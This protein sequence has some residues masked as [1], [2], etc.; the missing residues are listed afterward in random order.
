[1]L[2]IEITIFDLT[3][4]H[5]GI[6]L[7]AGDIKIMLIIE[8]AK[9]EITGGHIGI[10]L[11]IEMTKSELTGGHIGIMLIIEIAKIE[12][13]GGHIGFML[14]I[15]ITKLELTGGHIGIML[16]I[17]ITKL[18]LTAGHIG[19]MLMIEIPFSPFLF[20]VKVFSNF[21]ISY[22]MRL[23]LDE[24]AFSYFF[25]ILFRLV[26]LFSL[27]EVSHIVILPFKITEEKDA[28]DLKL[29]K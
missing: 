13:T 4:G 26:T 14:T 25:F 27:T 1:M 22:N 20:M 3:G 5:I 8:I 21:E 12:I 7:T 15:E 17:E 9:I 11:I 29:K 23:K 2:S 24:I 16:I 6:M 19:I 28:K 10:L 18:E